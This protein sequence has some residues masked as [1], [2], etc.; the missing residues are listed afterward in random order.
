VSTYAPPTCGRH[1]AFGTWLVHAKRLK[2][3]EPIVSSALAGAVDL[4]TSSPSRRLT[5]MAAAIAAAC[6]ILT[7]GRIR[8]RIVCV[9]ALILPPSFVGSHR[10]SMRWWGR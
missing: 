7:P 5:T 2:S 8:T 9:F 4:P 3:R 6:H 10:L 1:A